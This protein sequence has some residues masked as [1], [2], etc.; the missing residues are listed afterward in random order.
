MWLE[1]FSLLK[2]YQLGSANV[3]HHNDGRKYN[4]NYLVLN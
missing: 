1:K 3:Q 4:L 2:K